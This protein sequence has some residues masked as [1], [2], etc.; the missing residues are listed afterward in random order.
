MA[1]Y[2]AINIHLDGMNEVM[3]MYKEG[4]EGTE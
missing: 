2:L 4:N 3:E 1:V